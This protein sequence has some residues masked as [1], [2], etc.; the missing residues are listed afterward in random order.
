MSIRTFY[1]NNI[2]RVLPAEVHGMLHRLSIT[3]SKVRRASLRKSILAYYDALPATDRT[4]ETDEAICFLR[5][6][7][8]CLVPYDWTTD[9]LNMPVKVYRDRAKKLNYAVLDDKKIYFRRYTDKGIVQRA[10]RELSYEQ[11]VRSPHRYVT[12]EH[13]I[14]GTQKRSLHRCG[15]SVE[16]G[17]LVADVGA[18]DGIFALSI[19]ETA[20]HIYLFESDADWIPALEETLRDYSGKVTIVQKYV[21]DKDDA[22]GVTLDSYFADKD[23]P[24]FLKAD[25]EGAEPGMLRGAHQL[26]MT[27]KVTKASVC[28]YHDVSHPS[29]IAQLFEDCGYTVRFT[30]GL[31]LN[32]QEPFMLKGVL[33]AGQKAEKQRDG[34]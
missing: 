3:R 31:M 9:Y 27:G 29:L 26:L 33:W 13:H 34:N 25:I 14:L 23:G 8:F 19:A 2:A 1:F 15:H 21:S 6:N 32:R 4:A 10:I 11:D 20:G 30:D 7:K 17:D 22:T 16:P 18:A 5:S 24:I 28:V 12:D